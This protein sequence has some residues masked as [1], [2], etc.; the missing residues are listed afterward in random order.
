[1]GKKAI[2][3][4]IVGILVGALIAGGGVFF[5]LRNGAEKPDVPEVI[6]TFDIKDGQRFTLQK[7]QIPLYQTGSKAS[8]LQADFTIIF[9]NKEALTLA[10]SMEPDIKDAIYGVFEVKTAEELKE[11]GAREAMKEPV[12]EA[13]RELYNDEEDRENIVAVKISS[14]IVS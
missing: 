13:I 8:F 3:F 2:I 1:M 5:I 11:L 14:F 9:K 7:V 12:L 10:Q 6:P 4:I